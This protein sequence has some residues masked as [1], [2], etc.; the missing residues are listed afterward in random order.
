M[1]EDAEYIRKIIDEHSVVAYKALVDKY[2]KRVF[3]LCYKIIKSREEAEEVAQDTFVLCFKK[4]KDLNDWNKF[5]NWLLKIAYSKAIDHVRKKQIPKTDLDIVDKAYIKNGQ[6]PLKH[7]MIENRKELMQHAINQ[8]EP[9]EASLITL[10]YMQEVPVKE[11]ADITGLSL[12]NVK[13]KLFRAR[14]NLKTILETTLKT[15]LNDFLQHE[16]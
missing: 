13:V 9:I 10:Y 7:A 4:L 12:S 1:T 14:N 8:L 5:P 6:T 3:T 15:D 16:P 2:E 11:M